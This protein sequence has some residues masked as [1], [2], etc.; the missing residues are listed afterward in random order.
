[1]ALAAL[2]I[3]ITLGFSSCVIFGPPKHGK[4][5]HQNG[6]QSSQTHQSPGNPRS[7]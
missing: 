1:M 4:A 3:A 6:K 5:P 2:F 7:H